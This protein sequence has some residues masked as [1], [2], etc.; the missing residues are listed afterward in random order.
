MNVFDNLLRGSRVANKRQLAPIW[1]R[2]ANTK[3]AE[4]TN[5]VQAVYDEVK[6]NV[7]EYHLTM[8]VTMSIITTTLSIA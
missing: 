7:G 3:K 5:V 2:L 4:Y 6:T 8:V 1:A